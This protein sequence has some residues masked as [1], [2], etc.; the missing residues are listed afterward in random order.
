M[1]NQAS[2]IA[3][4][5]E[6]NK[7]L[8][9][10]PADL[11][12]KPQ[13]LLRVKNC[14]KNP[15]NVGV[16]L[17][18]KDQNEINH[19]WYD[20]TSDTTNLPGYGERQI[21]I[22][23]SDYP[24][25]DFRK[26]LP[27]LIKVYSINNPEI[28]SEIEACIKTSEIDILKFTIDAD[29]KT[30]KGYPN[31]T[32]SIPIRVYNP[33]RY[34][35]I[36]VE[37]SLKERDLWLPDWL[38]QTYS[39]ELNGYQEESFRAFEINIPEIGNDQAMADRS[40]PFDL[41]M[42]YMQN[43]TKFER[44][45]P[46]TLIIKPTG[47]LKF[48]CSTLVQ[49][50]PS[51]ESKTSAS[52]NQSR[53]KSKGKNSSNGE[54]NQTGQTKQKPRWNSKTVFYE[55]SVENASNLPQTVQLKLDWT[56]E[57]QLQ[58]AQE[59]NLKFRFFRQS[60]KESEE[61]FDQETLATIA[62]EPITLAPD[63]KET[64]YLE[65]SY[66]QKL[67]AGTLNFDVVAENISEGEKRPWEN[68][69]LPLTL[70]VNVP[71]LGFGGLLCFLMFLVFLLAGWR[72]VR[73][74]NRGLHQYPMTAVALQGTDRV[75]TGAGEWRN[76]EDSGEVFGWNIN[77]Y[78]LMNQ[79][80][81]WEGSHLTDHQ[82]PKSS[83]VRVIRP[84]LSES[85]SGLMAVG[86][87]NGDIYTFPRNQPDSL[88]Q[89]TPNQSEDDSKTDNF[90]DL[91]WNS[92]NV[93]FSAHGS[94]T[95]QR[96]DVNQPGNSRESYTIDPPQPIYSLANVRGHDADSRW[97]LFGSGRNQFGIWMWRDDPEKVVTMALPSRRETTASMF[98][99]IYGQEDF[100]SSFA[101]EHHD[102]RLLMIGDTTG[103]IRLLDLERL[104]ECFSP[105]AGK[106]RRSLSYPNRYFGPE[107][108]RNNRWHWD[109]SNSPEPFCSDFELIVYEN[110]DQHG[111]AAVRSVAIA[112]YER[113]HYG[114]SV[115][116]DGTVAL[117]LFRDSD[118]GTQE[119]NPT[120]I[121]LGSVSRPSL[122]SVDIE[123]DADRNQVLIAVASDNQRVDI[124]REDLRNHANCQ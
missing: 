35:G 71:S 12:S 88:T 15:V 57:E 78:W 24:V 27:V 110:R 6:N 38:K 86:L 34:R 98:S 7:Q 56:D 68:R 87:S 49:E 46:G 94:G 73:Y 61:R 107:Q 84:G 25:Q 64:L 30:I 104:R 81:G 111:G 5:D 14:S 55:M 19:D 69:R 74:W 20:L 76:G 45:Q 1:T 47:E 3:E 62:S 100:L 52:N 75:W 16:D 92:E 101:V 119:L 44:H 83:Q 115:G 102:N 59:R 17:Q 95:I 4:I 2:L 8:T 13:F 54:D 105:I 42:T 48:R 22:T 99:P 90:F 122:G 89:L 117:W 93:L 113:C 91:A 21:G 18:L 33:S 63:K 65:L 10:N 85:A 114:A 40:Y 103:S 112:E 11:K 109:E 32:K 124:Y 43:E 29:N 70:Q 31:K 9:F 106:P 41:E 26:E 120:P 28:K 82:L 72:L 116:D 118:V 123:I 60:K 53:T 77:R 39:R 50:L 23:I 36:K 37:L 58:E 108:R 80:R 67:R 51:P 79:V 66:G 97:L 96:W 121:E